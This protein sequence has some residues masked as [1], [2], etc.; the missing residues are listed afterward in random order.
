MCGTYDNQHYRRL[1][2]IEHNVPEQDFSGV[3]DSFDGHSTLADLSGR[4]R[5]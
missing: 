4:M 1:S 2:N 5:P 3:W